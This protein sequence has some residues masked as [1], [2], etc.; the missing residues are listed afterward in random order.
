M[1]RIAL[2]VITPLI[3]IA[4]SL[5]QAHPGH[6]ELPGATHSQTHLLMGAAVIGS[7]IVLSVAAYLLYRARGRQKVQGQKQESSHRD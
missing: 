7:V 1:N 2:Y 4:T 3:L 6:P 5:A